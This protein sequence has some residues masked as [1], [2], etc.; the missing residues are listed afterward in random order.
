MRSVSVVIVIN[1]LKRFFSFEYFEESLTL[2]L[3]SSKT[4]SVSAA[5]FSAVDEA[6]YRACSGRLFVVG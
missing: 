6:G 3:L 1:G 2:E 5:W 4:R